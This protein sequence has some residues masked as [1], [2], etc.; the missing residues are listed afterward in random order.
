MERKR[1]VEWYAGIALGV[2]IGLSLAF[3]LFFAVD[4][5]RSQGYKLADDEWFG[6]AI[7]AITIIASAFA[8]TA[9][10]WGSNIKSSIKSI[11]RSTTAKKGWPHHLLCCQWFY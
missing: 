8:A 10:F 4:Y 6:F 7:N 2:M 1:G 3:A 11:W 5:V 9:A